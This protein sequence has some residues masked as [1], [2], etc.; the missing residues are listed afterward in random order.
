[1]PVAASKPINPFLAGKR[2]LRRPSDH[3]DYAASFTAITASQA[4]LAA[5]VG[6]IRSSA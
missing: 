5:L 4:G 2:S 1:M 3:Q 6:I